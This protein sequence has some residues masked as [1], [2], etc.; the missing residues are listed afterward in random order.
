[1]NVEES[2]I[3]LANGIIYKWYTELY[4]NIILENKYDR[5]K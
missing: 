4:K 3:L 1:M 2:F 5:N